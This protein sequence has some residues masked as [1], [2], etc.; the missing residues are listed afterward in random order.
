MKLPR[1]PKANHTKF[2]TL[3]L[4]LKASLVRNPALKQLK[5]GIAR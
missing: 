5:K 1:P 3:R 2:E 4:K